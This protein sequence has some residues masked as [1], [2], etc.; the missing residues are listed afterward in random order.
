LAKEY[1]LHMAIYHV[2]MI[3]TKFYFC[4]NYVP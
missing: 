1:N 2:V 4:L 3:D